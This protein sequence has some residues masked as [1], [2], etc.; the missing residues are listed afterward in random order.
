MLFL[1][2]L[3]ARRALRYLSSFRDHRAVTGCGVGDGWGL[4]LIPNSTSSSSTVLG[5]LVETLIS[6]QVPT[7]KEGLP[8]GLACGRQE[9]SYW[10]ALK[11][12]SHFSQ[13]LGILEGETGWN[14]LIYRNG[15]SYSWSK[16]FK[17][18]LGYP[19]DNFTTSEA[20]SD[21]TCA[22]PAP[23]L[24]LSYSLLSTFYWGNSSDISTHRLLCLIII[25]SVYSLSFA[26]SFAAF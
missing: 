26:R 17:G 13:S 5:V 14:K 6:C 3:T 1:N 22:L 12:P 19:P 20:F 8:K 24:F 2:I 9:A 15:I 10:T 4:W 16:A 21:L 7:E 23:F 18:S 25:V 11:C